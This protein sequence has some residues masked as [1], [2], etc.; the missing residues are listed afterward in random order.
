[1]INAAVSMLR[2]TVGYERGKRRT[3]GAAQLA[4]DKSNF[5]FA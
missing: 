1:L 2:R 3:K 4:V 5:R